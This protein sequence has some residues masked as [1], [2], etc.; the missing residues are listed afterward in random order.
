MKKNILGIT[1][2]LITQAQS[3][4]GFNPSRFSK[5]APIAI[6]EASQIQ[7]DHRRAQL[8]YRTQLL[9]SQNSAKQLNS[10]PL[11]PPN[12]VQLSQNTHH[13]VSLYPEIPDFNLMPVASAPSPHAT[14]DHDTQ[15]FR[16]EK[17]R[18]AL[19]AWSAAHSRSATSSTLTVR[20]EAP[21]YGSDP[22]E[23]LP[24]VTEGRRSLANLSMKVSEVG[25]SLNQETQKVAA[26]KIKQ[27]NS[28]TE[29]SPK[30]KR[31]GSL[32]SRMSG[33]QTSRKMK[34]ME[35]TQKR[36]DAELRA[37]ALE[38]RRYAAV[39]AICTQSLEDCMSKST[40]ELLEAA[41]M[42]SDA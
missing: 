13:S 33:S 19:T 2:L 27:Q 32:L 38:I 31:R 16:H 8:P 41:G 15:D 3:A 7:R 23:S 29:E 20:S 21:P 12:D 11:S 17:E 1:L 22:L 26:L 18:E 34:E 28:V 14:C 10:F 39:A 5:T 25:R 4:D 30:S 6:P 37:A 40:Q 24:F 35:E 36:K 42:S 9:A